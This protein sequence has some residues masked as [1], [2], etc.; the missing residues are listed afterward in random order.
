MSEQFNQEMADANLEI[1]ENPK[2]QPYFEH[3]SDV[4]R[5][6]YALDV[7]NYV[8]YDK[9]RSPN[10]LEALFSASD[11]AAVN[12]LVLSKVDEA[13]FGGEWF[14]K[15]YL[16]NNVELCHGAKLLAHGFITFG[17]DVI[18][19]ESAQ[20]V[21]VGHPMHP[22]Q[23]H[24]LLIGP[25]E[26]KDNAIVGA[27]TIV[28]NPGLA[29]AVEIGKESIVLPGSIVSKSVPDYAVSAGVNKILLQG[30]A[31]FNKGSHS[32]NLNA[33]LNEAGI[34]LLGEKAKELGITLPD[35]SLTSK[36]SNP[37]PQ[38]TKI[39][40]H[41]A[42]KDI[43]K[44]AQFFPEAS[45]EKLRNGLFF[46]PNYIVGDGKIVLGNNILIN[47]GS[48][49][50]IDG[51]LV[52]DDKTFL[53]PESEITVPTGAKVIFG[54]GV[55]CGAKVKITAKEGQTLTIGDGSVL[56]AGAELKESVPP[57]SVVVG[58]GKVV[59]TLGPDN[60]YK[61]SEIMNDFMACENQRLKLRARIM[62]MDIN[63]VKKTL[64]EQCQRPA[65]Q[66]KR[67][68]NLIAKI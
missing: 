67:I 22:A 20:I 59:S 38:G 25:I 50:K 56:A 12:S 8:S 49:L 11:S 42:I 18:V 48:L 26:I 68:K 27:G 35:D 65:M 32:P 36:V 30:E 6:L 66:I 46:P 29:D 21:T 43:K 51:E 15:V 16:G 7:H 58:E 34:K 54:K 1:F 55:W 40:D 17:N 10:D 44:L 61:V 60:I 19:G 5:L 47:T 63:I 28:L 45:E 33:R 24:L 23:R 9:S 53:A 37:L 3:C 57:M 64:I 39:V 4:I 2:G 14:Q 31:Y 13:P 41:E 62:V 52:I